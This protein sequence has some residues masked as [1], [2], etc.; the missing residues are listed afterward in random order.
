MTDD[1]K[2]KE[3]R[4]LFEVSRIR[5]VPFT[6]EASRDEPVRDGLKRV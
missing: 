4:E 3:V 6:E 1:E 5:R 2:M